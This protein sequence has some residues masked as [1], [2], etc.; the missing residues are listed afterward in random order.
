MTVFAAD[1]YAYIAQ[2]MRDIK[3][4]FPIERR[5]TFML[6][7]WCDDCSQY[8]KIRSDVNNGSCHLCGGSHIEE[9]CGECYNK[10]WVYARCYDATATGVIECPG[11]NNRYGKI[12][13]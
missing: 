9:P 2:R 6:S 12:R 10:G 7:F 1:D 4:S 8:I 13:S 3:R 11:C 5:E